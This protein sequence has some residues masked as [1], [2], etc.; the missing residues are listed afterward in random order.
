MPLPITFP[1]LPADIV[2]IMPGLEVDSSPD[3]SSGAI[4]KEI[5][6]SA[7][8]VRQVAKDRDYDLTA[9]NDHQ[10]YL[11]S[12]INQFKPM[13]KIVR[14]RGAA[15]DKEF[16][17]WADALEATGDYLLQLFADGAF[18]QSWLAT[19]PFASLA[20]IADCALL[21]PSYTPSSATKPSDTR[22][23]IWA[24]QWGAV[25]YSM[26]GLVGYQTPSDPSTLTADQRDVYAEPVR[27]M[28]GAMIVR[29]RAGEYDDGSRAQHDYS[30]SL[31]VRGQDKYR[32]IQN[33]KDYLIFHG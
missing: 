21:V 12:L 10:V 27:C 19:I 17:R 4:T 22:G 26:G 15:S 23:Q 31:F 16:M 24:D 18:D 20:P 5:G 29:T 7:K 9:P 8:E 28:T 25:A 3:V 13:S 33:S 14:R 30:K 11:L 1:V 6:D 32:D 2:A